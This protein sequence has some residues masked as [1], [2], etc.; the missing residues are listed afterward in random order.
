MWGDWEKDERKGN[1][2]VTNKKIIP[3]HGNTDS[4]LPKGSPFCQRQKISFQT[5]GN[6]SQK[7]VV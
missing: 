2:L 4:R 7:Q 5:I 1:D 3:N 6:L